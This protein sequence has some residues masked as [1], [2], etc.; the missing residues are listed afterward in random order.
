MVP[1][2]WF[3]EPI[4]SFQDERTQENE[5]VPGFTQIDVCLGVSIPLDC[6][7][8]IGD[9]SEEPACPEGVDPLQ[10]VS[11]LGVEQHQDQTEIKDVA[12]LY[13]IQ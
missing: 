3:H 5:A 2:S 6:D 10:E 4:S 13:N 12:M 1:E 7:Q 11:I 8:E 9:D